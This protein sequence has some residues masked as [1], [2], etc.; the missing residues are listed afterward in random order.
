MSG[1][2][3]KDYKDAID[4]QDACNLSGVVLSFARIMER[5]NE[6]RR[7]GGHGTDWIKYHPI[8]R[9]FAEQIKHLTI[10]KDYNVAYNECE[11]GAINI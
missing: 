9:M 1:L 11:K 8:C 2:N 4:V 10:D 7:E 3:H 5:I 6:E